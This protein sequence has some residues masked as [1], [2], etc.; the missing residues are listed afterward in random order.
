MITNEIIYTKSPNLELIQACFNAGISPDMLTI[1]GE[2]ALRFAAYHNRIKAAQIL[3]AAG[4]S[5]DAQD[6]IGKTALH[7][8][9]S[10]NH[11]EI[12]QALIS[13]GASKR[14]IDRSG[15]TPWEGAKSTLRTQCP[16]L[17]P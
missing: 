9:A 16:E 11:L 4:A 6:S 5:C 14:A 3:I 1:M 17:K 12:V 15:F 10:K 8:A 7:Y 13:A 2:S